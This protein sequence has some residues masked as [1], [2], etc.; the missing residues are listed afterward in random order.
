MAK[1]DEIYAVYDKDKKSWRIVADDSVYAELP[2]KQEN[3]LIHWE[4]TDP[5]TIGTPATDQYYSCI[6][7]GV[8]YAIDSFGR[9]F[10]PPVRVT[11]ET[12]RA[13]ADYEDTFRVDGVLYNELSS[14]VK[15][16]G[17]V[18]DRSLIT[19]IENNPSYN[20]ATI[21]VPLPLRKNDLV[22]IVY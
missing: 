20:T 22:E 6:H 17:T 14:T 5:T 12:T 9:I 2:L 8:L 10:I 13:L 16:N 3:K 11:Y 15:I 21:T 4:N 19:Y 18:I 1:N 7:D